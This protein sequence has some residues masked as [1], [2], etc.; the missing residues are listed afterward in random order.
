MKLRVLL[1]A[2]YLIPSY[3]QYESYFTDAGL[4]IIIPDVR[5]RLGADELMNFAGEIDGII[6]GDDRYSSFVLEAMVPRLK[7]I[8]KWGTGIDSIDLEAAK[9]LGVQVFNTPD[10]FTDAVA[11]SVMSY[12]LAFARRTPWMDKA[13]KEERWEKIPGFALHECTL[14]I[15]GVGRIGM[16]V[17]RRAKPF[18]MRLLGNDIVQ[19]DKEFLN[20]TGVR[21]TD[22]D[23][24]LQRS[25][26][27]SLN[28][29]L[30]PTSCHLLDRNAL[31][32]M[33]ATAVLINTARGS[34]ILE[35]DL[36]D[37]LQEGRIAGAALD[38]FEDE[39]LS[40]DNPLLNMENVLLAPHNA[41]SSPAAWR[42]VHMNTIH[43]LF[44]GL[45][46]EPPS[47]QECD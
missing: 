4:E 19:I 46:L 14:G 32:K 28:C 40:A 35:K 24:L 7:V 38:V 33:K 16:A 31:E 22:M 47:I 1:T 43:N 29:D 34:V 13:M 42:R 27:V 15:I 21:M 37:V 5:E 25:D 39:P 23:E 18:G 8:S 41:N 9:R 3:A 10:A 20:E 36:I 11:D 6:S 12:V 26:F 44:L 30:N 17:S 45:G 2:P